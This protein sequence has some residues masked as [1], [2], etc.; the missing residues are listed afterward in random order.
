MNQYFLKLLKVAHLSMKKIFGKIANSL[1][2]ESILKGCF[3]DK[4]P[5]LKELQQN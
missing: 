4:C 1:N 3:L 2:S 5:T